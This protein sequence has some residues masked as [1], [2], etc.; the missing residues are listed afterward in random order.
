MTLRNYWRIVIRFGPPFWTHVDDTH[1]LTPYPQIRIQREDGGQ[2][3]RAHYMHPQDGPSPF[4]MMYSYWYK[5]QFVTSLPV[6]QIDPALVVPI[7]HQT[8]AGYAISSIQY[9]LAC[10]INL[11]PSSLDSYLKE[12]AIEIVPAFGVRA[13]EIHA[14]FSES[15]E[16]VSFSRLRLLSVRRLLQ[17]RTLPSVRR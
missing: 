14:H 9:H 5:D 13:T 8:E 16:F 12:R 7:P 3:Y 17:I 10:L 11:E 1:S 4:L 6:V 2:D 15:S